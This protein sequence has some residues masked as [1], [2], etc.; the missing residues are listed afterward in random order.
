MTDRRYRKGWL[1]TAAAVMSAQTAGANPPPPPDEDF[2]AYLGSWENGDEDWL[3]VQEASAAQAA[4]T[5]APSP[6]KEQ[7]R[8]ATADGTARAMQERKK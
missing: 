1:V 5:A 4:S 3:V 8:R 7:D 6:K 2:L